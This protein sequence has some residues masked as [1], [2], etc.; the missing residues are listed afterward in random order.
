MQPKESGY[1]SPK[2]SFIEE[3]SGKVCR[4]FSAIWVLLIETIMPKR[5]SEPR[6]P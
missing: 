6:I 1:K 2:Q 4:R 5:I 3:A